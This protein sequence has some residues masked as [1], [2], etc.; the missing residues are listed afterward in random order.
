MPSAAVANA[1]RAACDVAVARASTTT[2]RQLAQALGGGPRQ[3]LER[4]G[5]HDE[6]GV[7]LA[8]L[9]QR[10]GAE[11]ARV[12]A[13]MAAGEA[14]RRGEAGLPGEHVLGAARVAVA[15]AARA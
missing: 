3:V 14:H 13:R 1:T 15:R 6:R 7:D 8:A 12:G 10:G 5:G 9:E 4:I 11:L 2:A